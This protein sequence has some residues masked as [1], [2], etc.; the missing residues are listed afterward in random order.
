MELKVLVTGTN[1]KIMSDISSQLEQERGY[2][3][4]KCNPDR[5]K[6]SDT[7]LTEFTRVIIL[8]LGDE[9]KDSVAAYDVFRTQS[10]S[11][12]CLVIAITDDLTEKMFKRNTKLAKVFFLSRPVSM[13]AMYEKIANFEKE[14]EEKSKRKGFAVREFVNEKAAKQLSRK[15]ILVVDDDPE[16]LVNIKQQLEEFYDVVC[17]KSGEACFKYLEKHTPNLILLD[18]LMPI[19]D[20]PSVLRKMREDA[21]LTQ[22]PVIFLTGMT[23]KKT[24][25]QILTELRPQGY[26]IKPSK[27]SELVAEII[28][29]L[30]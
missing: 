21:L 16:Q 24:V 17:V 9:T 11:G 2:T 26:V 30:G 13:F 18:F 27:K 10:M 14:L 25:F 15:T 5:Y 3:V 8:C 7:L 4:I 19:M 6:L 22:I 20:G 29:V 1:R 23:E 12:E 28:E